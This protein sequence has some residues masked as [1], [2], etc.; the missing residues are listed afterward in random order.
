[1][2]DHETYAYFYAKDFDFDPNIIT[3][4]LKIPPTNVWRKGDI[5][6]PSKHRKRK[7][8]AWILRAGISNNDVLTNVH[9]GELFKILL[10][11]K[12]EIVE[13]SRTY[14]AGI[15]YVPYCYYTNITVV[16]DK[17]HIRTLAELELQIDFDVYS[18][19]QQ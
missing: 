12:S 14:R 19:S 15:S 7:E 1:M 10:P 16:L 13:L 3:E 8:N 18:L 2:T 4:K 17:Q 11:K 5:W 9:L 6:E